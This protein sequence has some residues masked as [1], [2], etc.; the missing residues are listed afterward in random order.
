MTKKVAIVLCA[1]IIVGIIPLAG[2]FFSP[3]RSENNDG[4]KPSPLAAPC[5]VAADDNR[6]TLYIVGSTTVGP[7]VD[8][9]SQIFDETFPDASITVSKPGSGAG[10][11]ALLE[12]RCDICMMSRFMKMEEFQRAIE[13]G[14]MPVAHV[15]AMDGICVIVHKSNPVTNLTIQQVKDIY[16]GKINN[17]SEVGGS[18]MDIVVISRDTESGTYEAFGQFVMNNE[19]MASKTEY[20]SSNAH[21]KARVTTTQGAIGYVGLGFAEGTVKA[22]R[23]NG[24]MPGKKTIVSGKYP[25]GRPLFL[26]TDGYPRIGSLMYAFCTFHLT[27]DGHDLIEE[28]SFV[29]LT[30]Y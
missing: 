15:V 23:I 26:F 19:P 18:N 11:E 29:P 16:Q 4:L 17:W 6:E 24:V 13:K 8:A 3:V 28:L 9:F 1:L 2:Q 12:K 22:I 20:G 30:D 10:A 5:N 7:I 14:V 27:E 25:I 21:L